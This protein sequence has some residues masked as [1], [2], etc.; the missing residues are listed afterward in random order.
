MKNHFAC[1]QLISVLNGNRMSL[2]KYFSILLAYISST[3]A[4]SHFPNILWKF[5][6]A[7]MFE[8]H[9]LPLCLVIQY[10]WFI[11]LWMQQLGST[12]T[13]THTHLNTP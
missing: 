8:E 12:Y 6:S 7:E 11:L 9:V 4:A 13:H 1:E 10:V 2:F 5:W 3:S